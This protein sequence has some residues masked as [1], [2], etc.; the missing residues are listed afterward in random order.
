MNLYSLNRV[1]VIGI[2]FLF[3][4]CGENRNLKDSS[5]FKIKKSDFISQISV[6]GYLEAINSVNIMCPRLFADLTIVYLIP[7]GTYVNKGDT[8][9]ILEAPEIQNNYE[10][11]LNDLEVAKIEY[12]KT[13]EDL[14]LQYLL[15]RS[16][17]SSIE[18]TTK[19]TK[20]DSLQKKFVS[21]SEKRIIEL[22]IKKSEIEKQNLE[23]KLQSL[24]LINEAKLKK[25]KLKI[26]QSQNNVN[27][28]KDVLDKL[29]IVSPVDGI[30][31]HAKSWEKGKIKE[32]D[33]VWGN[34]PLLNI[35][36]LSHM[37][38]KLTVYEANYKRINPGQKIFFTVDA[39]PEIRLTGIIERK[40]PAGRPI[41]QNNPVKVYDIYASID[42]VITSLHPGL[43]ISCQVIARKLKDTISIPLT[44]LFEEDTLQYV[45]LKKN[46]KFQ[47]QFIETGPQ[48]SSH[49][50]V[51]KGLKEK[52]IIS[53]I[54]PYKRL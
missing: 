23:Y 42:S 12:K 21:E 53:L 4:S 52:D 1:I 48:S 36:D 25:M 9:C 3:F 19:I 38:A 7:E 34:T 29:T 47:K 49:V 45:Y 30:I 16:Q 39:F 13:Y 26:E 50:V 5:L 41:R 31:E 54:S 32:G 18:A 2:I 35:P 33:I 17:V 11:S 10:N 27:R 28:A 22:E 51:S 37:S 24:K 8:V 6:G 15:L 14:Q 43:S 44:S 20:L 46:K 40:S